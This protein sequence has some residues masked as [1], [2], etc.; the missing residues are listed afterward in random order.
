MSN[1]FFVENLSEI[2]LKTS[3]DQV[4][5]QINEF[6]SHERLKEGDKVP[7]ERI[8]SEKFKVGR[9]F[10]RDALKK[11]EFYGII[12]KTATGGRVILANKESA[13]MTLVGNA[14]SL[15]SPTFESLIEARFILEIE[16]VGL[17][18]QRRQD[19]DVTALE[20]S[21]ELLGKKVAEGE[22]GVEEDLLFH[23][24]IAEASQN[25]VLKY[26]VS[27]LVSHMKSFTKEY[28]ICREAR[29]L[30]AY[31]EHVVILEHIKNGDVDRAKQT[32]RD[33]LTS[34]SDFS[35]RGKK[36]LE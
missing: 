20:E 14:M 11:M 8:L 9:M 28:D 27:Y 13:F 33:H 31:N 19:S 29:N 6:I 24:R 18:A 32:M 4:V 35:K 5:D 25:E 17:A 1:D 2:V 23:V 3:V 36:D 10:V 21:L 30:K 12:K 7:S 16:S 34:L 15:S 22:A 26:L